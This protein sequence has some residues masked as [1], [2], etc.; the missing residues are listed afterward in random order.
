MRKC[1]THTR[2]AGVEK[3]QRSL[4]TAGERNNIRLRQQAGAVNADT[5]EGKGRTVQK[6]PAIEAGPLPRTF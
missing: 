2:R 4:A 6:A 3:V 5:A 1:F